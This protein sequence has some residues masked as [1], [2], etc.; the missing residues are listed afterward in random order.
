LVLRLNQDRPFKEVN[1]SHK[2]L[3]FQE[4]M[5]NINNNSQDKEVVDILEEKDLK[6]E[7][8]VECQE[9][10]CNNLWVWEDNNTKAITQECHIQVKCL[11]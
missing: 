5:D 11:K 1:H 8:E 7:A 10:A 6:E 2:V 9:V 3:E 4:A